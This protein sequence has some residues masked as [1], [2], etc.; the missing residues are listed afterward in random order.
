M[1]GSHTGR[2][3][4]DGLNTIKTTVGT[5]GEAPTKYMKDWISEAIAPTYWIP[6][7]EIKV[8]KSFLNSYL[9]TLYS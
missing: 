7:T 5:F 6:N 1:D 3:V 2:R 8:R 9:N 4:L